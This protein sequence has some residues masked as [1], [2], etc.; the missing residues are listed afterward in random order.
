MGNLVEKIGCFDFENIK[1]RYYFPV[2]CVNSTVLFVMHGQNRDGDRYF[3]EWLGVAKKYRFVLAVPE[4]SREHFSY[5]DYNLGYICGERP[6][7]NIVDGLFDYIKRETGNKSDK[8][9][10]YGHSS[11]GQFVHRMILLKECLRVKKAVAANSGWYTF[12]DANVN[13]PCGFGGLVI[14][15]EKLKESFGMELTIL[16]GEKD[17]ELGNGDI[18]HS[19]DVVNQGENRF[20]RGKNF[21]NGCKK[22]CKR[23]G[24][25]FNWKLEKVKNAG[26]NNYEMID[27]AVKK[28]FF[29]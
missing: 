16:L 10:I 24:F 26:H 5:N 23:M 9:Y 22:F 11:G 20:E 18:S 3:N 15:T 21:Y 28:L 17:V 19:D 7:F 25:D 13:Y 27:C 12:P 14:D 8:Y 2:D 29:S 4:F 6:N 1:L